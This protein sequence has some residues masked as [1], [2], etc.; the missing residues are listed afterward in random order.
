MDFIFEELDNPRKEHSD[1]ILETGTHSQVFLHIY[2]DNNLE[3][4]HSIHLCCES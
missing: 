4:I 1:R 2:D 3:I